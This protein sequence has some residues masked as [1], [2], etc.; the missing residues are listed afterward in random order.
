MEITHAI[1]FID[2][3]PIEGDN[4]EKEEQESKKQ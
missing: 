1:R 2:I 3:E 4:K